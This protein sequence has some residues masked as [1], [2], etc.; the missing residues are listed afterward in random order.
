MLRRSHTHTY[1]RTHSRQGDWMANPQSVTSQLQRIKQNSERRTCNA[2][3]SLRERSVKWYD[4]IQCYN[5]P[6]SCWS[7]ESRNGHVR[8]LSHYG[9]KV[10]VRDQLHG[11]YILAGHSVGHRN[12]LAVWRHQMTTQVDIDWT[13][14]ITQQDQQSNSDWWTVQR[15]TCRAQNDT[16]SLWKSCLMECLDMVAIL[17]RRTFHKLLLWYWNFAVLC[18]IMGIL[19]SHGICIILSELRDVSGRCQADSIFTKR[20]NTHIQTRVQKP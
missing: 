13:D 3:R 14:V 7:S 6:K 15:P 12:L 1:A 16:G 10:C 2:N 5:W 20:Y 18:W 19:L 4:R 9:V 11:Q 17:F 8:I